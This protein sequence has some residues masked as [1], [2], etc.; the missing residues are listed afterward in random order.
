MCKRC[1]KQETWYQCDKCGKLFEA[2]EMLFASD[3][4]AIPYGN[5]STTTFEYYVSKCCGSNFTKLTEN[6]EDE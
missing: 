2:F 3:I 5:Q 6:Q 4:E 1:P